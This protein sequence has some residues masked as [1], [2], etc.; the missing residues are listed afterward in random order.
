[1]SDV[2]ALPVSDTPK[3]S[4]VVKSKKAPAKKAPA[5]HP[6]YSQMV[7][8]AIAALKDKKGSSRQA[9]VKYIMANFN[10]GTD[11]AAINKRVKVALKSGVVDT[12]I[13]QVKGTG[14]S[15]S[16]KIAAKSKAVKKPAA[17][18]KATP[19]KSKKSA[20]K[21]AT[22]KKAKKSAASAKKATTKKSATSAKKA[23]PKKSAEAKKAGAS[24]KVKTPKKV[25]AAKKPKTP[26]AVKPAKKAKTPKKVVPKKAAQ[27][28]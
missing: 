9:V 5:D 3:A 15:G 26:K 8:D 21:K 7:N 19:A 6:K 1:M 16:F 28:K 18:K 11:K 27:K 13:T 25:A 24:K 20:A 22:P 2:A 23:S 14:A 17:T 10:V 12:Q 4:E